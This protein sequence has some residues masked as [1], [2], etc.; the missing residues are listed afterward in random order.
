MVCKSV[1]VY[2][3]IGWG[4]VWKLLLSRLGLFKELFSDFRGEKK[5]D[6][7]TTVRQKK[8]KRINTEL[9]RPP[10]DST[11]SSRQRKHIIDTHRTEGLG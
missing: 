5:E 11:S 6:R 1:C 7:D 8:K 3:C 2:E 10:T 9:T 4:L